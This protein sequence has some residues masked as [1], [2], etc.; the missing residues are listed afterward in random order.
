VTTDF[1]GAVDVAFSV[2]AQPDGAIVAAG[3]TVIPNLKLRTGALQVNR[4]PRRDGHD[5]G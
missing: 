3:R 4:D 5:E 2:A 1:A